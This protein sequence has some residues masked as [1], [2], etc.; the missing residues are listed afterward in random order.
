MLSIKVCFFVK[1]LQFIVPKVARHFESRTKYK[2][3]ADVASGYIMLTPQSILP[4]A[5]AKSQKLL[6]E[7]VIWP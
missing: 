6:E 1:A 3:K 2:L 7:T 4:A 5:V